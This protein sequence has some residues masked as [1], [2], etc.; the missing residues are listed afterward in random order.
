MIG[1]LDN[2]GAYEDRSG[3]LGRWP[4]RVI[5]RGTVSLATGPQ[6]IQDRR[7]QS[8]GPFLG[9]GIARR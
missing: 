1:D 2:E 4:T 8:L 7:R 6:C 5:N 3:D 9:C